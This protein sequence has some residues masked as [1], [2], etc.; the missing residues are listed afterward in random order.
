MKYTPKE[1][2]SSFGNR[3]RI[4]KGYYP[5]QLLAVKPYADKQGNEKVLQYGKMR[6]FEFGI[7]LPDKDGTPTEPMTYKD[8][9]SDEVRDLIIGKFI[10]Y[11][12]KEGASMLTV[13]KKGEATTQIG[14][15][16]QSMGWKP[17]LTDLPDD[18]QYIGKWIEANVDDYEVKGQNG[19]YAASSIKTIAKYEGKDIPKDLKLIVKQEYNKDNKETK[20]HTTTVK[21]EKVSPSSSSF[22]EGRKAEIKKMR[23]NNVL[24]QEGYDQAM[25]Q[26]EN[27]KS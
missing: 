25:E 5:A 6:I 23:D 1:G 16:F 18:E 9:S 27:E 20:E 26:L 14:A 11:E 7:Y 12:S 4:K 2:G 10:Y 3:P 24:S 21:E 22:I 17:S 13:N 19:S 8:S 15:V